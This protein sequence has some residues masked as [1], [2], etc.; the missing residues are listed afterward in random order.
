M[1]CKILWGDV[2]VNEAIITGKSAPVHKHAKDKL[3]GGSI[4]QNWNSKG[5]GNCCR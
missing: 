4:M 5:T 2:H 3:I 1:D